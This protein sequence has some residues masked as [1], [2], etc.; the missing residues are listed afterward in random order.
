MTTRRL[1]LEEAWDLGQSLPPIRQL[2]KPMMPRSEWEQLPWRRRLLDRMLL[3]QPPKG[4]G[5]PRD[6]PFRGS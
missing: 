3:R 6:N 2:F 1:S 5:A 4:Y